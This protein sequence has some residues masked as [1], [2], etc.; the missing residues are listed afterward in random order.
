MK[1][2]DEISDDVICE[3]RW[4]PQVSGRFWLRG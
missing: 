4:D 3:L 2:G 1:T